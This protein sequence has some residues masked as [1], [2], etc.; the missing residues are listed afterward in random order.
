MKLVI[1]YPCVPPTSN[2]YNSLLISS[3]NNIGVTCKSCNSINR[4]YWYVLS[5]QVSALHFHWLD[6]AGGNFT[7]LPSKLLWQLSIILVIILSRLIHIKSVWT[8]HNLESHNKAIQSNLFYRLVSRLVHSLIAHSPSAIILISESYKVNTAKIVF[9]PHGSYPEAYE[10]NSFH[11]DLTDD[12]SSRLRLVY[13]GNVSP[14]KGIDLLAL[15]LHRVS[16]QL[17]ELNPEVSIIGKF[18]TSLY[19]ELA[20]QLSQCDNI[21]I[22]SDFVETRRLN[23][24]LA[25]A[26]LIV[27]P[28]RETLTS[29]SLIYALS[30]A[31]PVLISDIPSLDFYLSPTYSFTFTPGNVDSLASQLLFICFNHSKESLKLMGQSARAFSSTLD[32]KAIAYQT[33]KLY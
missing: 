7:L 28:F 12:I 15:A 10:V 11:S 29:G 31:K 13:F 25:A 4:V 27:L 19:P 2:P 1:H 20:L 5:G 9:I 18:N 22:I 30:S 14:Y 33:S 23:S 6:R 21:K 17:G 24:L 3:L 16:T 26:D 32:W 8:V